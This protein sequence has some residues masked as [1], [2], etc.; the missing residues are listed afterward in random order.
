MKKFMIKFIISFL[1]ILILSLIIVFGMV[2]PTLEG[3]IDYEKEVNDLE[4]YT[5]EN[6]YNE[7]SII[8]SGSDGISLT[9]VD[10]KIE[11]NIIYVTGKIVNNTGKTIVIKDYGKASA[12]FTTV[13]Y[14]TN[15]SDTITINNES[16]AEVTFAISARDVMKD[17]HDYPSVVDIHLNVYNTSDDY[18]G[19][20]DLSFTIS[21]YDN[22]QYE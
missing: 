1:G 21:W 18:T 20:S 19:I 4:S 15:F 9:P 5:I 17:T 3:V 22:Y 13:P 16:S 2:K 6:A 8:G 10:A 11:Y 12:N 14:T 7:G